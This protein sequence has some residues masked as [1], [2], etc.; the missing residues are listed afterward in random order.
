MKT[1][2]RWKQLTDISKLHESLFPLNKK[3]VIKKRILKKNCIW[4]HGF[5]KINWPT[6]A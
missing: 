1:E 5:L 6:L 2:S 3:K 4:M